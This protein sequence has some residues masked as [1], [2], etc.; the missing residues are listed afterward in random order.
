MQPE[1]KHGKAVRRQN[2]G[3]KG[4]L[5]V[6]LSWGKPAAGKENYMDLR[7]MMAERLKQYQLLIAFAAK[8]K[9]ATAEK[10]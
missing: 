6:K 1:R 9:Q 7:K 4:R 3:K 5:P 2:A 10:E 8:Q